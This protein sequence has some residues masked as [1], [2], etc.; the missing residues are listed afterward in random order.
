MA[1][2]SIDILRQTAEQ[3]VVVERATPESAFATILLVACTAGFLVMA[4]ALLVGAGGLRRVY[5]LYRVAMSLPPLAGAL[6]FG[7]WANAGGCCSYQASFSKPDDAVRMQFMY[8]GRPEEEQEAPLSSLRYATLETGRRG[9][10]RLV[11]VTKTGGAIFPLGDVF[12]A[13]DG[14]YRVKDAINDFLGA[15][16]RP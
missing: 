4:V 2:P 7:L 16:P 11:L 5:P 1:E 3:L 8:F 6:V 13:D 10:Y 9:D 12:T 15:S 14:Y